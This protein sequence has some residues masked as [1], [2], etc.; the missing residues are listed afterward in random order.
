MQYVDLEF[1]IS[2]LESMA[3]SAKLSQMEYNPA[4]LK[5]TIYHVLCVM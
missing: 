2:T 1:Q 5:S 4:P 3:L